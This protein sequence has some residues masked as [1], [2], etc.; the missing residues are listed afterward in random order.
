MK[1]VLSFGFY[2]L[3]CVCVCVCVCKTVFLLKIMH[4]GKNK[5]TKYKNSTQ[6]NCMWNSEFWFNK[7]WLIKKKKKS[8]NT[9]NATTFS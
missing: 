1:S 8:R 9:K 4:K 2:V 7:N 5:E 3:F 6:E